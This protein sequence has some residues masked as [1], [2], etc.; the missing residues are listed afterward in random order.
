MIRA[1]ALCLAVAAAMQAA[2]SD[3]ERLGRARQ[4]ILFGLWDEAISVADDVLA[5]HPLSEDARD[6]RYLRNKARLFQTL[7]LANDDPPLG[8]AS[9]MITSLELLIREPL[10]DAVAAAK[11]ALGTVNYLTTATRSPERL[12]SE[13][14]ADWHRI[15]AARP[16]VRRQPTYDRD[17]VQ[18]RDVVFQPYGGGLFAGDSRWAGVK[19]SSRSTT[20]LFV[21]PEITV[22]ARTDGPSVRVVT[23]DPFPAHPNVIFL[24]AERR[25]FLDRILTT[26]GTAR[27]RSWM[28]PG[29]P[30]DVIAL[31]ARASFGTR[32]RS[33]GWIVETAPRIRAIEFLDSSRTTAKV[34]VVADNAGARIWMERR[35]DRWAVTGV[36]NFWVA[37][38]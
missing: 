12:I 31:W 17:V 37:D 14:L 6:A 35:N 10:D 23:Y 4:F 33:G 13:A 32:G 7:A 29:L 9:P 8:T 24:D 28:R 21:R 36:R 11:L 19:W 1:L 26:L 20:Y 34:E 38:R 30:R 15:D 3:P 22:I 18:I 27:K 25:L 5:R 2:R 16:R